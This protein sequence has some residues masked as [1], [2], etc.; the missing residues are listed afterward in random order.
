M[1]NVL[2]AATVALALVAVPANAASFAL[3]ATGW[4]AKD[5]DNVGGGGVNLTTP[6]GKAIDF[7]F[8]SAYYEELESEP[9]DDF[10]LEGESPFSESS[11]KA[12]PIELGLRFN[13]NRE[14]EVFHPYVGGGGAYYALDS[15]AGNL[16]DEIGWYL[17]LGSG[18]GN[19]EGMDFYAD[20][21]YRFVEGEVSDFGDLDDDGLDDSFDIDLSGPVANVGV[22]WN[23]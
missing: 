17:S 4:D 1:K 16:D 18:F 19:G 5:V 6:L 21:S 10:L 8:R 23:W 15:D 9:F 14:G 22:M 3:Y 12:I 13:L 11:L 20:F 7:E 2:L